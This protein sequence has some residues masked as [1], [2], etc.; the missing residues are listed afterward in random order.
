MLSDEGGWDKRDLEGVYDELLESVEEEPVT[1]AAEL[2]VNM[3][4]LGLD[5]S[6]EVMEEFAAIKDQ[7]IKRLES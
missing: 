7:I 2:K 4:K 3:V 6:A 1:E 5:L